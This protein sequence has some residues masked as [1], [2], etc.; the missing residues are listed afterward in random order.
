MSPPTNVWLLPVPSSK[1]N[2]PGLPVD[3]PLNQS[4]RTYGRIVVLALYLQSAP[5]VA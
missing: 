1:G 3:V 2:V 5:I 4:N